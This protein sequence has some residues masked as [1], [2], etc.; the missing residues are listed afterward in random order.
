MDAAAAS[1]LS[2]LSPN[3]KDLL[4]S[5]TGTCTGCADLGNG[6]PLGNG[7]TEA[8]FAVINAATTVQQVVASVQTQQSANLIDT[9][10]ALWKQE[11]L[12]IDPKN[13]N[14]KTAGDVVLD[15]GVCR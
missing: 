7:K 11:K 6:N 13:K 2:H 10:E 14:L 15:D 5:F 1:Q 8:G 12:Q 9:F 4:A 3:A